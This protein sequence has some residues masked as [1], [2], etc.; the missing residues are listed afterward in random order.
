MSR[1]EY[2]VRECNHCGKEEKYD[3]QPR[4]GGF[5]AFHGWWQLSTKSG[6]L[7]QDEGTEFDFCSK[8][9]VNNFK[10]KENKNE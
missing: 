5:G 2:K 9:C 3:G 8:K 7:R 6:F 4:M 1:K 10:L